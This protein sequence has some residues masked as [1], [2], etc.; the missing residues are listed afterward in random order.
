VRQAKQ[1]LNGALAEYSKAISLDPNLAQAYSS[2]AVIETLQGRKDEAIQDFEK[3]F[4]IEPSL[5]HTFREFFEKRLGR[6]TP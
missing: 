4:K 6:T 3:A 1:D 2:R 5:R